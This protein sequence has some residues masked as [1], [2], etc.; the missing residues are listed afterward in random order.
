MR[1]RHTLCAAVL[2]GA[3]FARHAVA[4]CTVAQFPTSARRVVIYRFAPR[5]LADTALLGVTVEFKGNRGGAD[6]VEI[7]EHWAGERIHALS[8]LR[9]LDGGVEIEEAHGGTDTRIVRHPPNAPVRLA[10]DLKSEWTGNFD[11]PY[12]FH[13][14]IFGDYVEITGDN[15][16]V[17]PKIDGYAPVTVHFDWWGIPESWVLATSFGTA[18]RA[19]DEAR[20]PRRK[21][22]CQTFTGP[23]RDVVDAV[24]AAG[25]FRVQRFAI[26]RR[27]VVLAIRGTWPYTDSAVVKA[28]QATLGAN[29]EFWHDDN[30][31]YFLVTWAP[32]DRDHGSADGTAFTNAL[33][34]FTSRLDSLS[35]WLGT[36]THEGFHAWNP[37]RMGREPDAEERRIGWFHEGFTAYYQDVIAYRA[38]LIPLSEVVAN[39]NRDLRN[40]TGST[41]P[42]ARGSVIALWLDGEIRAQSKGKRSLDEVMY[43]MVRGADRPL[44]LETILETANRYLSPNDQSVLR[45]AAGGDVDVNA[46]LP[47]AGQLAPCVSVALDSVWAFDAGFDVKGSIDA[48]R[49]TGVRPDGAA[50]AA[51][52]RDGQQLVGWSIDNGH[53]EIL[54][55]FT[56]QPDTVRQR[57][58]YYPRGAG[59]LVPQLHL[60][61]GYSPR[62]GVCGLRR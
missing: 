6:T 13:P 52:L 34:M 54:A 33:W 12:E 17:R 14:V 53:S 40:V 3:S 16:L 35:T 19:L 28:V 47:K 21:N 25:I 15:S 30:F 49:V 5:T 2:L 59:G 20:D 57:I 29:R 11:H 26:G 55:R 9:A 62:A 22:R 38:G 7:P 56:V 60:A 46:L 10:Y 1:N 41:S 4:Q 51:G 24:Y 39:T 32:F 8:N 45:R 31:P 44:T 43:A 23:W 61:D 42:Y 50:Y 37:R 48:R 18:E 36:L 58:S 27:P